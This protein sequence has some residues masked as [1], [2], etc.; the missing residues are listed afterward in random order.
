MSTFDLFDM[1][2]IAFDPPENKANVVKKKIED[3]IADLQVEETHETQQLKKDELRGKIEFLKGMQGTLLSPDGR[4]LTPDF[5]ALASQKTAS[6][7][8]TLERAVNLIKGQT[9]TKQ[10]V[11]EYKKSY[12][13][14]EEN[15][16][17]ILE[18]RLVKIVDVNP[19][20]AFPKFPTHVDEIHANLEVLKKTNNPD[21]NAPDVSRLNDL[22][23]FAAYLSND[24]KRADSYRKKSRKDLLDIVAE[25]SG[26]YSQ[27]N[28]NLGKLIQ[29]IATKAQSFVFNSDD[30]CDG[31]ERYLKYRSGELTELFSLLKTAPEEDKLKSQIAEEKIKVIQKYFPDYETALA[32]YNKEAGFKVDFYAPSVWTYKITCAFCHAVNEFKSVDEAR[33]K[34][35]CQACQKPLFKKC[36]KCFESVPVSSDSCPTCGYNFL[37][38]ELFPE[39]VKNAEEAL[40]EYDFEEA[41]DFLLKARRADPSKK[42]ALDSLSQRIDAV[43]SKLREP[44]NELDRLIAERKYQTARRKLSAIRAQYPSINVEKYEKQIAR[45]LDAVFQEFSAANRLPPQQKVSACL[46]ILARCADYQ[47]ALDFLRSTPPAPCPGAVVLVP[48]H[49]GGAMNV[50]WRPSPEQGVVYRLVRKLGEA[51]AASEKDGEILVDNSSATSFVD[52]TAAPGRPYSYSV[53]A[54]RMNLFSTPVSGVSCLYPDVKNCRV[55]QSAKSPN[56]R[57]SWKTPRNCSGAT[58]Y[59]ACD[60]KT[61]LL[62]NVP[63][64]LCSYDDA[65]VEYDK[66]YRYKIVA[67]YGKPDRRGAGVVLPSYTPKKSVDDFSIKVERVEGSIY[68]ITWDV[69]RPDVDLRVLINDSPIASVKSGS[70]G[71]EVKLQESSHNVVEVEAA[72]LGGWKRGRN[73]VEINT[74]APCP[75]KKVR[76]K[77]GALAGREKLEIEIETP[78]TTRVKGFLYVVR[79]DKSSNKWPTKEELESSGDFHRAPITPGLKTQTIEREVDASDA[80]VFYI[81]VFAI[82][83]GGNKELIAEPQRKRIARPLKGDLFWSA[84]RRLRGGLTLNLNLKCNRSM[85]RVPRLRLCVSEKN[86]IITSHNA[87]NAVQIAE[88]EPIELENPT[89]EYD[90]KEE[91]EVNLPSKEL[92]DRRLFLFHVKTD[93]SEDDEIAVRWDRGFDGKASWF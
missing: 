20:K 81:S 39:Y 64:T 4:K 54:S 31:Y 62:A 27:R 15:I 67:Q 12:R 29:G 45:E 38:G 77:D 1:L 37:E 60:G 55:D 50:S 19:L 44:I 24:M 48:D 46:T 13:L 35:L 61:V 33:T 23:A 9:V 22:Y 71:V 53:F 78:S 51:P 3:K 10:R 75:I 47:P 16:K 80:S 6:Q 89:N 85:E 28:D 25:A 69:A 76:L 58:L 73:K 88:L 57:I 2:G 79:N 14:S 7:K 70:G 42:A 65:D 90:W 26:K 68:R 52:K 83:D 11:R 74:F 21:P 8:E 34:N 36:V 66:T 43:K 59:R 63:A 93:E 84:K 56:L 17:K 92:K 49:N 72:S 41:E 5:K 30:N 86:R 40:K 32:I 82:H 87:P 18:S 91:I